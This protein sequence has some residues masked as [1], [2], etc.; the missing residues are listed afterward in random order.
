MGFLKNFFHRKDPDVEQDLI[1][2]EVHL[3][4]ALQPV[5]LRSEFVQNL[6]ARLLSGDIPPLQRR[7][8][9]RLSQIL[10]LIGGILGSVM[11][12]IA[13][14]RGMVLLIFVLVQL[15]RCY[16]VITQRFNPPLPEQLLY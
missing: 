3:R 1:K 12:I 10:L 4:E 7:V 5:S 13:G 8:P 2:L 14:I 6:Q 11:V 9:G 15:I 16:K